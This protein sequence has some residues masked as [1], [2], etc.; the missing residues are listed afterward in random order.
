MIILDDEIARGTTVF[1]LLTLLREQDVRSVAVA[2][3]HGLFANGALDKLAAC[4]VTEIVCTN[5]VPVPADQPK[6]H[7][8]SVG[9]RWPRPST[10]STTANR[11]APCS[12]ASRPARRRLTPVRRR[13]GLDDPCQ[14]GIDGTTTAGPACCSPSPTWTH[15]G[16]GGAT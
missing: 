8:L 12:T 3:A 9:R 7:V 1:E 10:G 6:L 2:C 16:A 11:S 4:D 13:A 14:D 5:S 15:A